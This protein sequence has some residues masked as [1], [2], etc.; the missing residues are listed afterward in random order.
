M[1]KRVNNTRSRV[2]AMVAVAALVLGTA[3]CGS[4]DGGSTASTDATAASQPDTTTADSAPTDSADVSTAPPSS[5]DVQPLA[6]P[7]TVAVETDATYW[8]EPMNYAVEQGWFEEVGIT[9]KPIAFAGDTAIP[10][11]E[12]G[13][14]EIG[15]T[16][17]G[18]VIVAADAGLATRAMAGMFVEGEG[19]DDI[20]SSLVASPDSGITDVKGLEGKTIAVNELRSASVA[21]TMKRVQDAG[22]DPTTLNW[23]AIPFPGMVEAMT[24]GDVDA[25]VIVAPFTSMAEAA[26]ATWISPLAFVNDPVPVYFAKQGWIDE[27]PD[28]AAAFLSVLERAYEYGNANRA[29]MKDSFIA[30]SGIPAEMAAAL[31]D[32]TWVARLSQQVVE[33][34]IS[35]YSEFGLTENDLSFNDVAVPAFAS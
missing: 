11:V 32:L 3:A 4:D 25:A 29:E 10:L 34:N 27:H 30:R 22:G 24:R 8:Q 16:A 20:L 19:R 6:E 15:V 1:T 17:M 5:D 2:A 26:G 12:N 33:E 14:A 23:V 18:N 13:E 28:E 35:V 31:P 7:V 9:I 21:K